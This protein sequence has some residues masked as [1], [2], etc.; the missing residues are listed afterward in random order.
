MVVFNKLASEFVSWGL[1]FGVEKTVQMMNE[2]ARYAKSQLPAASRPTKVEQEVKD[3]IDMAK[4]Y[5]GDAVEISS[6]VCM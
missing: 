2:G 6:F 1:A 3:T 4:A 5:T